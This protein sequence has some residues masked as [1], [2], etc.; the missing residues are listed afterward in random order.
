MSRWSE[1]EEARPVTSWTPGASRRPGMVKSE[2]EWAKPKDGVWT[3]LGWS[4]T[5]VEVQNCVP[6]SRQPGPVL[7]RVFP[8]GESKHVGSFTLLAR[9]KY[10]TDMVAI[11]ESHGKSGAST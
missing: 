11:P 2:H 9:A 1:Q 10:W 7:Y 6:K 8:P 3:R 4:I 5:E